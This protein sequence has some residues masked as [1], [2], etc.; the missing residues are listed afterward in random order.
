MWKW[1]LPLVAVALAITTVA[2]SQLWRQERTRADAL[3]AEQAA[4]R[5]PDRR[6]LAVVSSSERPTPPAASAAPAGSNAA[7]G[8][9]GESEDH[10]SDEYRLLQD[11][12]Y[13]EAYRKHRLLELTRG[14]IEMTRV[15]GISRATADRL[16]ARQ[17]DREIRYLGA[18]HRN[19]RTEE[20]RQARKLEN[21]RGQRDED[22][23]IGAIIGDSNVARWHAYQN[24]LPQ[25]YEVRAVGRELALDGTALRDDQVDALVEAMSVERQ[26]IRKE[27]EQFTAGLAPSVGLESKMRGYRDARES[28]LD[29]AAEDRIRSAAS[30]ILA[31][32]QFSVF[33]E[34]RRGWRE[35]NDAEVAMY[36]A[37]DEA[38]RRMSGSQ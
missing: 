18:P 11:D 36:R 12:A 20:E 4:A 24:S 5:K 26:R 16:L 8:A 7:N 17:V 10:A 31:P 19:P 35:A 14:H 38:R 34:K 23:E 6:V 29:R 2:F 3:Q 30:R 25:R 9:R 15:L 33:V 13:R 27:L 28:E 21:E 22:V 1:V 32:E 37:A